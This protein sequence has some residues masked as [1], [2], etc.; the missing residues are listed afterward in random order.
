[1]AKAAMEPEVVEK[2]QKVVDWLLFVVV[3]SFFD[4]PSMV[5]FSFSLSLSLSF[6]SFNVQHRT[7]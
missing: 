7:E 1:M 2:K 5:T 4:G 3:K 6:S